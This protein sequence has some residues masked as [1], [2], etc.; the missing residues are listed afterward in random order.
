MIMDTFSY[1]HKGKTYEVDSK[2]FLLD[3]YSW[4]ENFAKGMA[5]KTKITHGLTKDHWDVINSIRNGYKELD[6]CPLVYETCRMNSMRIADLER[7]FPTGYM[8]GACKLAGIPFKV[9]HLGLPYQPTS[10]P[11]NM[12]FMESYNKIYEVDVQGFL[13]N[14]EQ[15]D[16]YY[17]ICRAYEMKIHGGNLTDKHWQIIR[18]LRERYE[19]DHKVPSVY[20]TCKENQIDIEELEWLFPDGYHRSAVKIAGLRVS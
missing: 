3:F 7:L 6:R 8:R 19:N 12:S 18:F 16:E 2:G 5:P 10:K 1:S 20:K 14:P 4:D 15:W 13:V 9:G 17:A 11:E